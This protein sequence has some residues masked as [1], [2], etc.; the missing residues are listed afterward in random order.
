VRLPTSLV[1][2]PYVPAHLLTVCLLL[3][4]LA[5]CGADAPTPTPDNTATAAE[6]LE[7]A[8][9]RLA[10]IPS[11]HFTLDVEGETFVD[12]AGAIRLIGAEGDLVRPDKVSVQFQ[13]EVVGRTITIQLI[14][15]GDASWT[16]NILTGEW[17]PAPVEFTYRPDILFST[18]EGIG[19]VMGAV[20]NAR[21]LEDAEI[22]GRAAYHIQ[23]QVEQE[24]VGPLTYYS[25]RGSPVSVN[26]WIDRQT[27]DLLRA[28]L[29]EPPGDDR[30]RPATW[31]LDLSHHGD[32]LVIAPPIA[33]VQ[34]TP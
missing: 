22:A 25:M 14:T 9:S 7:L 33:T 32:E 26:L 34:A 24:L 27:N 6:I 23:G 17:E 29:A 18:Q 4:F 2:R 12:T 21:R 16:T 1:W 5:G 30:P 13:A 19:P 10:E 31:T 8:S 3:L 20:T 15:I 28:Q 11:A